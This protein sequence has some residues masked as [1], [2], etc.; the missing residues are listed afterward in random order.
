VHDL[1][2]TRCD[3]Y[4]RS[5]LSNGNQ[6]DFHCHSN[7]TRAVLPFGLAESDVHDVINLFQVTGLDEGGR[8]YMSPCPARK[9]DFIEFLAEQ[10]VLM[11]LSEFFRHFCLRFVPSCPIGCEISGVAGRQAGLSRKDW[12][13]TCGAAM[14]RFSSPSS[15][16][17]PAVCYF[18]HPTV[19]LH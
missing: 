17:L 4:I 15:R 9:G 16:C 11:A 19:E 10:D 6:Y 7:L 2:G 18:V 5:V 12:L 14:A 3:P 1:L 13:G 8:Y